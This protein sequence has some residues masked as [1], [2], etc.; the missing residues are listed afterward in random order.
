VTTTFYHV[1]PSPIGDLMLV[2]NGEALTGVYMS[3]HM[4]GPKPEPGWEPDGAELEAVAA[5][6][7]AYFAGELQEFDLPLAPQG[8]EFQK[9]VWRE[10]CRIPFGE[11]ISYGELARRIGQP[12]AC[13]AVGLANGRNPIAIIVPC[14]RVIGADGSLTGY[15][16]GIDRK[17]W[18][19]GH[20]AMTGLRPV[21]RNL[22]TGARTTA[23]ET[24]RAAR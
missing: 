21:S 14:H 10:L 22:F 2:S 20:E 3:D 1:V 19:L 9:K 13:R 16:G 12:T 15:G 11:T 24:T 18:L 23:E 17:K 5:Q 8:T 6:L 4:G 7:Q